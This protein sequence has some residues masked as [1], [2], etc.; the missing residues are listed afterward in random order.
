[1]KMRMKCQSFVKHLIGNRRGTALWFDNWHPSGPLYKL[2][3]DQALANLGRFISAN[4]SVVI[5]KGEWNWPRPRSYL[6]QQIQNLIPSSI[7]PCHD[8]EDE[9]VWSV[10]I[11]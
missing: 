6:I 11:S 4:V 3:N 9:V 2:L 8:K 10:S 7:R 1:M 5:L